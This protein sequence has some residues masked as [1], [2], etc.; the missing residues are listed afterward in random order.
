MKIHV[1]MSLSSEVSKLNEE[2]SN[3]KRIRLPRNQEFSEISA[4]IFF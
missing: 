2:D 4:I 1:R 3:N